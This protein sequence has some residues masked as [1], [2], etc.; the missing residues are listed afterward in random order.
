MVSY[1]RLNHYTSM[2]VILSLLVL[3]I[4][5]YVA[6]CAVMYVM[7]RKLMYFPSEK[8][9]HPFEEISFS[10]QGETLSVIVLN[11]EKERAVLYFGG[12]GAIVATHAEHFEKHF[13][14]QTFY[15][16][17]YRGY[18]SSTGKP[19]EAGNFA[20]ALVL[21]DLVKEKH[22]SISTSGRSLGTGVATY[23]AV[24]KEIDKLILITPYDSILNVAKNKYKLL[25]VGLL[26]KDHYDSASRAKA[27]ES[28]VLIIAAQYDEVIP[29]HHTEK[30]ANVFKQEQ[31]TYKVIENTGH[32]NLSETNEYFELLKAFL[33]ES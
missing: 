30:L 12:N 2:K 1:K 11:P 10:N 33:K 15:F 31:L 23:L 32:N 7:Q 17:N 28:E 16:F 6:V 14:D 18:G 25:P 3:A 9:P 22:T 13:S 21:Y 24:N 5:L 26:L 29:L 19:T 8:Y 20:D 27:V 4:F